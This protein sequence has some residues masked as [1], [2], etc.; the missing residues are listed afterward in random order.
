MTSPFHING[1]T[2]FLRIPL[3]D[4]DPTKMHQL[5]KQM[6]IPRKRSQS[7]EKL[8]I[9]SF[10]PVFV[11]QISDLEKEYNQLITKL[12]ILKKLQLLCFCSALFKSAISDQEI[13]PISGTGDVPGNLIS[14]HKDRELK[15]AFI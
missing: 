14:F 13:L 15:D 12:L 11:I 6:Q 8:T 3:K 9:Q 1:E 10:L 2:E 5:Q 7:A 4:V